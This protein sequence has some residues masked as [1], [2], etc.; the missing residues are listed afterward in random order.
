M[1]ATTWRATINAAT[2][3]GQS[4]TVFQ[5]EIDAASELV[6]FWRFN[7]YYA[8][9]LYAEQPHSTPGAWNRVE[10]RPRE[11]FVYVASPFNFTS[12]A[13]NLPTA[14]ALMGNVVVWKPAS[15]A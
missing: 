11:G 7:P 8:Q 13:G 6:D 5:A 1:L 2:M 12:I 14:P 15:S 4:K 9:Q 10:Y 3:L